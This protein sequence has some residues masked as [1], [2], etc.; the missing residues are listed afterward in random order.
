MVIGLQKVHKVYFFI[1]AIIIDMVTLML[2]FWIGGSVIFSSECPSSNLLEEPLL[3][4]MDQYTLIE[5]QGSVSW[6]SYFENLQTG[7]SEF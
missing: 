6:S 4:I 5:G 1:K 7:V 2:E 3:E